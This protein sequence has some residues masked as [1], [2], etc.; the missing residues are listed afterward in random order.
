MWFV[1]VIAYRQTKQ[2][3][4]SN[5]KLKEETRVGF[6]AW[7]GVTISRSSNIKLG[8]LIHACRNVVAAFNPCCCC[9][10]SS[11]YRAVG[12]EK[13]SVHTTHTRHQT[14][15][16]MK[17]LRSMPPCAWFQSVWEP[18]GRVCKISCKDGSLNFFVAIKCS[19]IQGWQC[20]P[21]AP[22]QS[23]S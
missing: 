22:N 3:S 13:K 12:E 5:D 6:L 15:L 16:R 8:R 9:W 11:A 14:A 2:I 21:M 1:V 19:S 17:R 10:C 23:G 18:C 4:M 20:S 7:D